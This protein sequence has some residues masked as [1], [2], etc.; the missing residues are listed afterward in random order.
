MYPAHDPGVRS[1]FIELASGLSVRVVEAGTESNPHVLLIPGWGCGAWTY[2]ET[3]PFLESAGFHVVAAEL[4]GHGQSDKPREESEYTLESM[5]E[6]VVE[7]LD[8]LGFARCRL[9]GHSMGGAIAARVAEIR[10]DRIE[11][12][13]LIAPVGF[14]G[15]AGMWLFRA[16]T[17][18]FAIP[19]LHVVAR[20]F[21]VSIMLWI[22][23]GRMGKPSA[24]DVDEY[25]APTRF[26]G[27]TR[28]L[29]NLLHAFDWNSAFSDLHVPWKLILGT[30]DRLSRAGEIQVPRENAF[31]REATVVKGA[32]HALVEEVP[33]IVGAAIVEFFRE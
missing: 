2:H 11:Q 18:G 32:G 10:P 29:R 20:R 5:S 13:V 1:R 7:I 31:S 33:Q 12:V 27:F 3:I 24:R 14:R 23:W 9:I 25:W 16:L 15:V 28:A 26:P 8:A 17:P 6:H 4:K 21:V 30:N 19:A 22:A